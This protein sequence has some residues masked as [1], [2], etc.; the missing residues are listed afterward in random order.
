MKRIHNDLIRHRSDLTIRL[1]AETEIVNTS[2]LVKLMLLL[3]TEERQDEA[4]SPQR[5]K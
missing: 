2:H 1:H 5:N 3:V 4:M